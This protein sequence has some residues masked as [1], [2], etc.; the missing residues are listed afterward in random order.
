MWEGPL[1]PDTHL[2]LFGNLL[3][4]VAALRP[5]PHYWLTGCD[6]IES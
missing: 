2:R 1:R 5:L 4:N 6:K 3:H